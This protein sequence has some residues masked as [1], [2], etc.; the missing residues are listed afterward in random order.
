MIEISV[1]S[2]RYRIESTERDGRWVAS[3]VRSET[4]E[5]FGTECSGETREEAGQRMAAWIEWQYE[6]T[7]ALEALQQAEHAYHR[8]IAGSAFA[9]P[10]EGPSP[11]EMQKESLDALEAARRR[12]DEVRARKPA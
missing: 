7:I 3:A 9:S 10:L 11:F 8:T 1:G 6:H 2:A 4:G 12:L 5:R